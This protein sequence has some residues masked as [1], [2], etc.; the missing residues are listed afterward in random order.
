MVIQVAGKYSLSLLSDVSRRNSDKRIARLTNFLHPSK[1]LLR[2]CS[3]MYGHI[4]FLD[5]LNELPR[6]KKCPTYQHFATRQQLWLYLAEELRIRKPGYV[7]EFGVA[8]GDGTRFWLKHLEEISYHGFDCFTGMPQKYRQVPKGV[9]NLFGMPPSHVSDARV[10]WHVGLVEDTLPHFEIPTDHPKLLL[11]DLDLYS[12]TS[13]A[14]AKVEPYL[15]PSDIV[16]F[17]EAW[18]DAEGVV[19]RNLVTNSKNV[20]LLAS[21]TGCMAIE[22]IA[23]RQE[24]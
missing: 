13:F 17:D 11:F 10:T 20:R 6:D 12:P 3:T 24:P 19:A 8:N 22:F 16:Y 23:A 18:D 15:K 4:D 1:R 5:W 14:L 2:I 9:F 7:L 21:A